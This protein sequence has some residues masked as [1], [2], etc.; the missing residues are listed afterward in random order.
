M[1]TSTQSSYTKAMIL[2]LNI[3]IHK[4]MTFLMNLTK[5]RLTFLSLYNNCL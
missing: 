4:L 2:H 3:I 1:I 5:G